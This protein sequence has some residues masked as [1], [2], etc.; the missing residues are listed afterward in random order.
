MTSF[1]GIR[2]IAKAVRNIIWKPTPGSQELFLILGQE[3]TLVKEVL[4]HGGRG[5]GKS[6][7]LIMAYLQHVGKGWGASWTGIIFK[8][9][10]K[11]LRSLIEFD[12]NF[13]KD[14][15]QGVPGRRFQ[16]E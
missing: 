2:P 8:K 16:Q 5:I 15:P 11:P 1:V 4:F 14:D 13:E 10:Y 3:K 12:R 7:V 6:E 9:A